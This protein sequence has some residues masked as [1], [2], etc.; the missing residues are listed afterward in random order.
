MRHET[1]WPTP[2]ELKA[3]KQNSGY[4]RP[5]YPLINPVR[6]ALA[7]LGWCGFFAVTGLGLY[8]WLFAS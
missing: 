2:E 7:L 3:W 1:D 6:D 8:L 4:T 5:S